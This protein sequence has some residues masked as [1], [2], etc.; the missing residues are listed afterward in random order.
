MSHEI[1]ELQRAVVSFLSIGI[2]LYTVGVYWCAFNRD[3]LT[4][5]AARR[6]MEESAATWMA[7]AG[8]SLVGMAG[9]AMIE[10]YL[11]VALIAANLALVM[12]QVVVVQAN[13][14]GTYRAKASKA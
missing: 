2:A 3:Y 10:W 6:N 13:Y 11:A 5:V 9:F 12:L 14:F 8:F 1:Q 7:F 4:R